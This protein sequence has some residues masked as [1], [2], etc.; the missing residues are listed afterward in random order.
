M[1]CNAVSGVRIHR[2][3]ALDPGIHA[4]GS[5]NCLCGHRSIWPVQPDRCV[6][7]TLKTQKKQLPDMQKQGILRCRF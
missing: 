1:F 4:G 7:K 3:L 5:Y 2:D 6:P